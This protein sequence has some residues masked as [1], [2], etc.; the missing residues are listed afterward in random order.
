M[1][2]KYNH[3]YF[4]VSFPAEYVAVVEINRPEKLNAFMEVMWLNLEKVFN[5]LSEDPNVRAVVLTGAGDRAFCAGLDVQA[6][7]Q[8]QLSDSNA[9]ADGARTATRLRRHIYEFQACITAIEKCEKPVIAVM[10][11]ISYGLAIDLALAADVRL[12]STDVRMS[13]KEVDIGLAADIGTLNRLPHAGVSMSWIKEVALTAREFG[14][15]EALRVGLVSGIADGK[16]AVVKKATEMAALIASKSPV[17]VQ[18]TKELINYSRGRTVEESLNYTAV[19]NAG[20][21]QTQD[22]KDAMTAGLRK[23]KVS[24]AKL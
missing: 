3:D 24:F 14:A 5:T 17:A 7:A 19:W 18:G 21:L 9:G 22:M 4:K 12:A 10:H 8:G 16:H 13:V 6:A 23:K 1:A 15:E 20:M 11:G 2:D